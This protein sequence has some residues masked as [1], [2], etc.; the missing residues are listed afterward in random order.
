MKRAISVGS[1]LKSSLGLPSASYLSGCRYSAWLGPVPA[2]AAF[3]QYL[4]EYLL[5]VGIVTERVQAIEYPPAG[6]VFPSLANSLARLFCLRCVRVK[7]SRVAL[8]GVL[9]SVVRKLV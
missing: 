7:Q 5:K 6:P 8:L 9:D 2:E 1:S 4:L 3:L